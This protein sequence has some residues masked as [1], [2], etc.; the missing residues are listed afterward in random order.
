MRENYS[1]SRSLSLMTGSAGSILE[2]RRRMMM[3]M[4]VMVIVVV[5]GGG[6][7]DSDDVGEEGERRIHRKVLTPA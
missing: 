2:N 1:K 3:M 4:M 7:G 6:N 5:V